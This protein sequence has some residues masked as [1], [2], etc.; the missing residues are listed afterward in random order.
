ML[1]SS[2]NGKQYIGY[3]SKD[4]RKRLDWH[5]WGLTAWSKQNGPFELLYS[6]QF[7]NKSDALRREKY[8][9]TGQGRRGIEHLRKS[10][11]VCAKELGASAAPFGG[12]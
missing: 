4:L 2:K 6:E 9:K 12:G 8:F 11:S 7:E 10:S 3:T 5:R 1:K